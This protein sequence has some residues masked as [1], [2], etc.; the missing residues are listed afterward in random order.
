MI[1]EVVIVVATEVSLSVVVSG[2]GQQRQRHHPAVVN[3]VVVIVLVGVII[4]AEATTTGGEVG[5]VHH[6]QIMAKSAR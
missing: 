4:E 2:L 1:P 5:G 3:L 6:A